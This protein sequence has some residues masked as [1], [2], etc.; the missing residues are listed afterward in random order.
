[1]KYTV[2]GAAI[3]PGA[4]WEPPLSTHHLLEP[5]HGHTSWVAPLHL[6]PCR[7][8]FREVVSSGPGHTV[9]KQGRLV[10]TFS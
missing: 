10:L 1:M 8:G 7:L 5:S 9:S 3:V 4:A 2:T 6:E